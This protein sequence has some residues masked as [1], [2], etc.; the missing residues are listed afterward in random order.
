MPSGAAVAASQPPRSPHAAPA[1]FL[2]L[3]DPRL[4]PLRI[5]VPGGGA[6]ILT[7][8]PDND[9]GDAWLQF[10]DAQVV[11]DVEEGVGVDVVSQR[12]KHPSGSLR[13]RQALRKM[14]VF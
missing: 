11:L 6:V 14:L 3:L 9:A 1:W 4:D 2:A 10:G 12:Q 5:A 7:P 13:W 8:A